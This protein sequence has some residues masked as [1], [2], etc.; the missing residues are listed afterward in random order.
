[1]SD[2]FLFINYYNVGTTGQ[3]IFFYR[4]SFQDISKRDT[5]LTC[6]NFICNITILYT[7]KKIYFT[8][9]STFIVFYYL[10]LQSRRF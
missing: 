9:I 1:M 7:D 4:S 8:A 5:N 10:F 2:F 6:N 3:A